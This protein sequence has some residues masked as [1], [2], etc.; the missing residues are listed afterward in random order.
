MVKKPFKYFAIRVG[1]TVVFRRTVGQLQRV[2]SVLYKPKTEFRLEQVTYS[3]GRVI[4]CISYNDWAT[5]GG[6]RLAGNMCIRIDR[7]QYKA[8][9]P[10]ICKERI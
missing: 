6:A 2:R 4:G 7:A 9:D 8:L 10:Y 1:N 3:G 5:H